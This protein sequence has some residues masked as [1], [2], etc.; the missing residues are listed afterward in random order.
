MADF[1]Y[2]LSRFRIGA[3]A[4]TASNV[5]GDRAF[6]CHRVLED[7]GLL[8]ESYHIEAQRLQQHYYPIEVCPTIPHTEKVQHMIDW[9]DKAHKLLISYG[10]KREHI[11]AAVDAALFNR[12]MALREETPHL[13]Y[14]LQHANVPVLVF[15]AGLG[16]IIEAVLSRQ[17]GEIPPNV[18]VISNYMIF[19][20]DDV[21][22]DFTSPIFHVFNKRS[23]TMLHHNFFQRSDLAERCNLLLLGDSLGDL[24]MADG[25]TYDEDSAIRVGFLNDRVERLDEY[26][27][28]YDAVILGDPSMLFVCTLL[29]N[30]LGRHGK[31][32]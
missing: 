8:P 13:F 1:D 20:E 4:T 18:H 2:T 16:D 25:L 31:A 23:A 7:C 28:V 9:A 21:L 15:S 10:V 29:E 3:H 27:K 22:V 6:S 26:L 17:L 32:L 12:K 30:I 14:L 11:S 24:H 19:N 5:A